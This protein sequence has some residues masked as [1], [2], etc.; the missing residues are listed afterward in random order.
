[1]AKEYPPEELWKLYEVLPKELQ[2]AIFSQET[3]ESIRQACE[4]NHLEE[5]IPEVAKYVG[6][7][8]MGLL[9]PDNFERELVD[10]LKIEKEKA[11]N[12]AQE[13]TRFVFFPLRTTLELLYK[14]EI[15]QAPKPKEV[16][17]EEKPK[18]RD[19]YREPL[20]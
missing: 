12:I 15:Q 8:L 17:E 16:L 9:D 14:K 11:K 4:R 20:E 1:M 13:I 19:I 7:V 5:K 2:E 6:L 18:K 10:D 3:S